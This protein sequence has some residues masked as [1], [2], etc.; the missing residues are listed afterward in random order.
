MILSNNTG[1]EH[2]RS[3][4]KRIDSGVNTQ[5]SNGTRQHSCGIQVSKSGGGCRIC[6]IISRHINSLHRGDGSLGG[7]GNTFLKSTHV[8]GKSGLVT[9]SGRNTSKKCG[10]LRTGLGETENV[11][12]KKQHILVFL[13]TEV[14]GNGQTS[15]SDTGA[16]T[17]GLVHL[18]VHKSGLGT[19]A[20]TSGF[21]NLDDTT[22]NHLVVKIVTFTSTFTHT[23]KDRVTTV[24]DSNVVNKFHD[25]NGFSDTSTTEKTN[26]SSLGIRGKKIY[27]LDTC[28]KNVLCTTLLSK[29]GSR[30][31]E[32]SIFFIGLVNENG[33]F[34]IDRFT[35]NIDNSSKSQRSNRHLNGSA[36]V[37][38]LLASDQTIS[39]FHSNG[40]NSVLSQMLGNFQHKTFGSLGNFDLKG[41]QNLRK[42]LR[43]LNIHN[44]TDDL[45]DG[46]S[47]P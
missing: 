42:T 32:R 3:R 7:G 6:K 39:R 8:C 26:L 34:L 35:D 29:G 22:L 21:V 9:D 2:S 20:G 46:T 43:K 37:D 33:S 24:V 44:G 38:T 17:W 40:T 10:H 16:G 1:V 41:V 28:D 31:M 12:N 18:T 30:T 11:I 13:I 27:D 45:R 36:R 5:L 25:N 23:G 4:V 19:L 47:A 14:L 15:K